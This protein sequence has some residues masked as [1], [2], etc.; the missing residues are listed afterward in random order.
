MKIK[1]LIA[2]ENEMLEHLRVR[3]LGGDND[4][5]RVYLEHLRATSKSI[6][7]WKKNKDLTEKLA[8]QES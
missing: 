8:Q 2:L 7:E 4:A 5:A 3:A 6:E 1:D